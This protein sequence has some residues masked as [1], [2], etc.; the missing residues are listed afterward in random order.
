[1]TKQKPVTQNAG[2]YLLVRFKTTRLNV[3][4]A[5]G[6]VC[7]SSTCQ[8]L[9]VSSH[10]HIQYALTC[11]VFT[12]LFYTSR[13]TNN[14]FGIKKGIRFTRP[15]NI[16]EPSSSDAVPSR[17]GTHSCLYRVVKC[18]YLL[19]ATTFWCKG[20]CFLKCRKL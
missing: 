15:K 4:P 8:W 1:M 14:L 9:W 19:P 11:S 6:I 13:D 18:F 17:E 20:N 3:H 7:P 16:T 10:A 12:S 2:T 5:A